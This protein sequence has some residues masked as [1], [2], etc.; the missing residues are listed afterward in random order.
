M[1]LTRQYPEPGRPMTTYLVIV[2]KERHLLRVEI[3]DLAIS[4][5]VGNVLPQKM[6]S[7]LDAMLIGDVERECAVRIAETT[8]APTE[9]V[10]VRIS[11]CGDVAGF[12]EIV[13]SYRFQGT[14]AITRGSQSQ[15]A[16]QVAQSYR[17]LALSWLSKDPRSAMNI[18]GVLGALDRHAS[19]TGRP[20]GVICTGGPQK[21]HRMRVLGQ[22]DPP[23]IPTSGDP[24]DWISNPGDW[25][26]RHVKYWK[27]IPAIGAVG[28]SE[29]S[30]DSIAAAVWRGAAWEFRCPSCRG[31]YGGERTKRPNRRLSRDQLNQLLDRLDEEQPLASVPLRIYWDIARR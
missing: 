15:I 23:G 16:A 2:E 7:I 18:G 13:G 14:A 28:S 29:T 11:A 12:T 10:Y 22:F 17:N 26:L 24:D 9:N 27:K 20:A 19:R 3:P 5:S 31:G 6:P 21:M 1:D 25:V 4:F 30:I 8:G